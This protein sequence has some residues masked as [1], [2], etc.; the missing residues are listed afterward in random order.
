MRV[1]RKQSFLTKDLT[2]FYGSGKKSFLTKDLTFFCG[3]G[4]NNLFSAGPCCWT[5]GSA[6]LRIQPLGSTSRPP[7]PLQAL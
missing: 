2:F 6:G 7:D 1:R 4:E 3:S 5:S